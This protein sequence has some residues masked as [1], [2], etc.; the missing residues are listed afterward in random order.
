M[1]DGIDIDVA[2]LRDLARQLEQAGPRVGRHA[3]QALRRSTR[4]I[5]KDSASRAPVETGALRD[6]ITSTVYGT[7]NSGRM[8]G[9]VGPTDEAGRF[10]ENGTAFMAPQPFMRPAL[11]AAVPG[12][13]DA[14]E[15]AVR[16]A[17]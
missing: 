16:D 7:G 12:F 1:A 11:E 3:S 17:L 6:S 2:P 9:V 10:V 15:Q 8:T 4:A 5:E 13:V 14:L